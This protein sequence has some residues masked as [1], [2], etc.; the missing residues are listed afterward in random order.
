MLIIHYG[1]TVWQGGAVGL[2]VLA[3]WDLIRSPVWLSDCGVSEHC[4]NLKDKL[5]E[6]T[7]KLQQVFDLE[8]WGSGSGVKFRVKI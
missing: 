1:M 5:V 8:V 6:I 7:L 2:G 3:T 4:Y